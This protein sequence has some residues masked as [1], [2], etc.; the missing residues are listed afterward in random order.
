MSATSKNDIRT[1]RRTTA[2]RKRIPDTS[3]EKSTREMI[4]R[5]ALELI[6]TR[7]M[8]DFRIDTLASSL[9]LSPGNITYH[10]SRKEEI[11]TALWEQYLSEYRAIERSLTTLFD[12]KQFY[13]LNRIG[14]RLNYKYRG[15]LVFR[16]SDVGAIARD[17][18]AGRSNEAEHAAIS[19]RILGL[20]GRNG[21]LNDR[22]TDQITEGIHTYHYIASQWGVNFA[23]QTYAPEEVESKLDYLALLSIHALYPTLSAKGQKEFGEILDRVTSGNLLEGEPA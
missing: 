4:L 9:G 6:N 21:Y 16:G 18:E 19:R 12:L 17:R 10:F 8:V 13:L 3:E 11:C 15:V 5:Q 7:G 20:L 1:A 22:T 23:Y 14:L 2:N